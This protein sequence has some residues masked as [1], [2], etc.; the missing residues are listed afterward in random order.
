MIT[1][2]HIAG[3][4]GRRRVKLAVV[5]TYDGRGVHHGDSAINSSGFIV[6]YNR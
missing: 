3:M 1:A 4:G 5:H 6:H 2:D